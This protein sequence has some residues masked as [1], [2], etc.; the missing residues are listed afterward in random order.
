[1]I[2]SLIFV[3]LS[4]SIS[5]SA[6]PIV[7]AEKFIEHKKNRGHFSEFIVPEIVL[8]CYQQSTLEDLRRRFPE[9]KDSE[10]SDLYLIDEGKVGIL[11]GWGVGA[12][13]LA[14]KME[15]L[16]VLGT[17]AFI[18][19]GTA[20]TLMDKH[21]IG[22]YII[23]SKALAEDGVAHL[24]L[25][26]STVAEADAGMCAEWEAFVKKHSLP[27]FQPAAAWSFSAMFR[28]TPADVIRV[29]ALGCDVVEMEAATLFAI[30]K[31]KGV[32]T[33]SLFVISDSVTDQK[34]VPHIKGGPVRDN[35]HQLADW[36]IEFCKIH[37]TFSERS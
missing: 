2:K 35:L 22:D 19:V 33:L 37:L 29:S 4:L 32:Q 10:F 7:T 14:V 8:V 28:E 31:E 1:M 27:H 9:I 18:A 21:R 30:G 20:G 24:Y 36:A 25:N 17:Q 5:L 26:G 23:A 16:I 11:G 15:Q 13:A 34:W 3:G 6:A 12:P